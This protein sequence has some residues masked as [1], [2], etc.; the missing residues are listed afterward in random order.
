[1]AVVEAMHGYRI[2]AAQSPM[3]ANG[4]EKRDAAD[5]DRLGNLVMGCSYPF[6]GIRNS[7]NPSL[8]KPAKKMTN[9]SS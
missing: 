9:L 7:F 8:N 5:T 4:K 2:V 1:M 3:P 6:S